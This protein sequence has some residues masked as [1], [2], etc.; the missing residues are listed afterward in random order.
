MAEQ[1]AAV[2]SEEGGSYSS[3]MQTGKDWAMEE[4]YTVKDE[5]QN[6]WNGGG[7]GRRLQNYGY[8]NYNYNREPQ[9]VETVT[10]STCEQYGC[11]DED[12]YERGN[13]YR[14]YNNGNSNAYYGGYNQYNENQQEEQQ[15]EEDVDD[16]EV[17][18]WVTQMSECMQIEGQDDLYAGFICNDDGSG[19]EIGV[20]LDEDCTIYNGLVSYKSLILGDGNEGYNQAQQYQAQQQGGGYNYYW[21]NDQQQNMNSDDIAFLKAA[22]DIVTYPFT[23]DISC[24]DQMTYATPWGSYRQ[25]QY[26]SNNQN[27]ASQYCRAM[28]QGNSVMMQDCDEDAR[29]NYQYQQDQY[30]YYEDDQQDQQDNEYVDY[31]FYSYDLSQND[32]YN[33]VTVCQTIKSYNGN[34]PQIYYGQNG[35]FDYSEGASG[36]STVKQMWSEKDRFIERMFESIFEGEYKGLKIFGFLAGTILISCLCLCMLKDC[37]WYNC[38]DGDEHN[39][40]EGHDEQQPMATKL[41]P[42]ISASDSESAMTDAEDD[43]VNG[44]GNARSLHTGVVSEIDDFYTRVDD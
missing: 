36:Q 5:V 6:W 19:V 23:H 18:E 31:S 40:H 32:L 17:Y 42:D 27:G 30:Q 26:Y 29:D 39:Y 9:N 3:W 41:V 43:T 25:S 12:Y 8:Y 13:D 33:Q 21:N 24:A 2:E 35:V 7:S 14:Y 1:Y 20:F 34:Y 10:C 37:C 4:W 44:E 38:C 28:F 16:N 11:F 15:Q 22:N